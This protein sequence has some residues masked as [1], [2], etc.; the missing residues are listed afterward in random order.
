MNELNPFQWAVR[1]FKRYAD[2][3]GRS[4][5][6]EYWWYALAAGITGF[7][8]GFVDAGVLHARVFGNY[9]PLGLIFTVACIVPGIAV[10]VRR[11]HDTERSGWWALV[12][13]PS[14]GFFLAGGSP[15]GV[16]AMSKALPTRII[17]IA[18]IA[19]IVCAFAVLIF[20]VSEGTPGWNRYGPD[21]YGPDELEE[22]FA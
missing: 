3:E 4:P 13:I 11:L 18:A 14:Y 8:L 5:R 22:V 16:A 17:V 1:P 15:T 6:A 7:T 2:F 12:R 21:P 19:W 9:G 10:L 20:A